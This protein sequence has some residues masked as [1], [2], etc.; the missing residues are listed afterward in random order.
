M[1]KWITFIGH[2]RSGHTIVSAILDSHPN[3]RLSEEQKYIH[4]W[5]LEGWQR[6]RIIRHLLPTGQGR[7][8]KAKALP[9]SGAWVDGENER[10]AMGDKWGYDS[11]T[12][13]R[14][15]GAPVE[16]L[17][18]F[19]SH[20]GMELKVIHTIRDP[21]DNICAW[22]DSPKYQRMFGQ[23]N[24]LY[25]KSIRQYVRFYGAADKLLKRHDHFDLHNA[26]MCAD[27]RKVIT[28]LAE[29]LELPV[30]EPWLTNAANSVFKK[31]NKRADRHDWPARWVRNIDERCITKWPE[32]FER[33]KR[34]TP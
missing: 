9:G 21:Y 4:K 5:Y 10:L 23:G 12:L 28:E 3:V 6:K 15:A 33:Y 26:E 30:V 32:Y 2:G 18:Q 7:E 34:W 29:Y 25:Q 24:Q 17:D 14:K 13:V 20:M 31:P 1:E 11:V 22:V 8:R 19:T 27:P 16:I